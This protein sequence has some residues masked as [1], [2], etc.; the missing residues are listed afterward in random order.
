M[1]N[2]IEMAENMSSKAKNYGNTNDSFSANTDEQISE[3]GWE[4]KMPFVLIG[5][6]LIIWDI[7]ALS[8]VVCAKRTPKLVKFFS[9]ALISFEI[10]TLV[11]FTIRKFIEDFYPNI[12]FQT[13]GSHFVLLSFVTVCLISAERLVLFSSRGIYRQD[14]HYNTFWKVAVTI[15]VFIT[16]C[17]Y[18]SRYILCQLINT[19]ICIS[20]ISLFFGL[21]LFLA[22]V[23]SV[24][25]YVRIYFVLTS[26]APDNVGEG[27]F[28]KRKLRATSLGFMYLV[29]TIL[30]FSVFVS[31]AVIKPNLK[32]RL[33][34]LDIYSFI[35]CAADPLLHVW[36]FKECQIHLLNILAFCRPSLRK[37]AEK[38]KI[39]LFDIVTFTLNSAA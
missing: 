17:F 32:I 16:F 15:W 9:A 26:Q 2:E 8:S 7:L 25:C 36:W 3:F 22:I 12:L 38:M 4:V 24:S 35:N 13:I 10:S 14:W 21:F 19:E 28:T 33:L 39:A 11:A 27:R 5:T 30:G 34:Q 6:V 1:L 31:N 20:Y 29:V 37:R 23:I 18:G